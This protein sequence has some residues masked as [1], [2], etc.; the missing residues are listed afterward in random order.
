[1]MSAGF[2]PGPFSLLRPGFER[3]PH[4]AWQRPA[5]LQGAASRGLADAPS[6]TLGFRAA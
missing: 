1:M 3:K 6:L 4:R 2:L 5:A